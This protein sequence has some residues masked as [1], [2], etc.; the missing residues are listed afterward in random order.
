VRLRVQIT[1]STLPDLCE[2]EGPAAHD[3]RVGIPD[4]MLFPFEVWRRLLTRPSTGLL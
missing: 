3:F 2:P 4:A 1:W